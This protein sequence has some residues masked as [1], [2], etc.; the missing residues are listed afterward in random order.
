MT[1]E[2]PQEL[3]SIVNQSVTTLG[4]I[5]R[6]ELGDK[7]YTF[8][9]TLRGEMANTRTDDA[10]TGF[11]RLEAQLK[12]L[13]RLP[14]KDRRE[15]ALAYT[16]MLEVMNACENA[17]R[18]HRLAGK[19]TALPNE[20]EKPASIIYVLT[21]HPTE[22]RSP[23]NIAIFH[24]VQNIILQS[25]DRGRPDIIETEL[26]HWLG[27]AWR[28][29]IVRR[30]SPRVKDEAGHIYSLLFRKNVLAAL[31]EKRAYPFFVRSWVG[32]D[33]DGHPGVNE[34]TLL[35]SLT[36]SRTLVLA[37]LR[38]HLL[39]VK[40]TMAL[41]PGHKLDH[42]M[43]KLLGQL[44]TLK[45]I[46]TGDAKKVRRL[47]ADVFAFNQAYLESMGSV[48]PESTSLEQILRTFPGLVVPLELRESSDMLE[49]VDPRSAIYKM[50]Q[51][52]ERISRGGNP[53]WY[54]RGFIISMTMQTSHIVAAANF[55]RAVFKG[56]PIPVIP[57]FENAV[58]LKNS[59]TIVGEM[60]KLPMI[61]KAARENWD[62]MIELMVGYSDSAKES[63]AL[64]SRWS[65]SQAL[66]PLEQICEKAKLTAV[67]FHGSG[68]SI[69]RGGGSIDDQTSWWPKAALRNYKVTIQGEMVERSMATPAIA[70]RQI[71]KIGENVSLN[72]TRARRPQPAEAVQAF[73]DRTAGHYRD[74]ITSPEFLRLV[75]TATPYSYLNALKIGSRPSKRATQLTVQGLRAI[76]WILCWTQTR[77][78]F[79]TWWGI[80]RAWEESSEKEK[81]ELKQAFKD[82]PVFTSYI[83]ALGFTLAKMNLNIWRMYLKGAGA[84]AAF[85]DFA[86]EAER[87][88]KAFTEI[89]GQKD[90]LWYR[91]W[92]GESVVLRSAMIH[93]LNLLQILA[94]EDTDLDLLRITVTGISCGMLTTG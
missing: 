53:R 83:K 34:K 17:Y 68:G 14:A 28:A 16:L 61:S 57:L 90:F 48:H 93:P 62:G 79:P 26:P 47:R 15:I 37:A 65:I 19:I 92:L 43:A 49:K 27:L 2:L 46:S 42:T 18:S 72:L 20:N 73:A 52:V 8:I 67:F 24:R 3:R 29:S 59:K 51:T 54:A 39:A 45:T 38:D 60:V 44:K 1:S 94:I 75:E 36:L 55:Q 87:T 84:E 76:P 70:R 13:R 78:L 41:V 56:L 21:A 30:R 89:C 82:Q 31:L 23:Q 64:W 66:P 85:E 12:L 9:E 22:A 11:G 32:G 74:K 86:L 88:Q 77:L 6:R 35:E 33:K 10:A 7:K 4:V 25:L 71:E 63:G 40:S 81:Q 91:P 69:D 5:L 58:A 50:L 80:G